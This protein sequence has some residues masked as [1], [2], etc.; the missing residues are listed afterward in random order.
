LFKTIGGIDP[1][2]YVTFF[3]FCNYS[4]FLQVM[5]M[6]KSFTGFI[7]NESKRNDY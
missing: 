5:N 3:V 7:L 2:Q 6:S 4:F 1:V